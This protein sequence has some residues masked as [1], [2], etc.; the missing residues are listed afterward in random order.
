MEKAKCSC[1]GTT[2]VYACAGAANLG[3]ACNEM[4]LR[5]VEQ[6]RARMGCLA[7]VGG[8]VPNM[9]MSARSADQVI[10]LDGCAVQCARKVLEHNDVVPMIHIVATDLGLTKVMGQRWKGDE[11]S[12]ISEAFDRLKPRKN[13]IT[14]IE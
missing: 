3:Q 10:T 8:H 7:G 14:Q 4:A 5:L 9:V 12:A 13:D 11:V 2:I 6:G 1:G